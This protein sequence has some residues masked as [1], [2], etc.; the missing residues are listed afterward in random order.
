MSAA[1]TAPVPAPPM[2]LDRAIEQYVKLRD[3]IDGIKK[4]NDEALKPYTRGLEMLEAVMHNAMTTASAQS[5]KTVSGTC[6]FSTVNKASVADWPALLGYIQEHDAW[7]LLTK[8]VAKKE[9]EE[10]MQE[11]GAPVPGVKLDPFI[12][13]NVRRP[14]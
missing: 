9:V 4:A 11:T 5:L 3:K 6:F 7:N 10:V 2:A 8:A 1:L 14:S 12:K 13:V